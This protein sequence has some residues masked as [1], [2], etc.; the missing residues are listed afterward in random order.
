MADP[1]PQFV[2]QQDRRGLLYTLLTVSVLY[3]AWFFVVL[4]GENQGWSEDPGRWAVLP[5][6]V[7]ALI[8]IVPF[9]LLIAYCLALLTIREREPQIYRLEGVEAAP[10]TTPGF[11]QPAEPE[12]TPSAPTE[13]A[14]PPPQ[15]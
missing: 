10:V 11:L 7:W 12:P 9:V 15:S 1:R 8:G 13:E 14:A 3:A 2:F 5:T 4:L 6:F